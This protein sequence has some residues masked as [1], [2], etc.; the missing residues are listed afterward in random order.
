MIE[1]TQPIVP[2]IEKQ[3]KWLVNHCPT[4][5]GNHKWMILKQGSS[6]SR[7][8]WACGGLQD[9]EDWVHLPD[10]ARIEPIVERLMKTITEAVHK[11]WMQE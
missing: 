5:G 11:A 9:N 8:C 10:I 7:W 2:W 6:P 3:Q 4:T 1:A